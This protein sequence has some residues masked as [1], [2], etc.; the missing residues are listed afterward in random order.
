MGRRRP[1][2]IPGEWPKGEASQVYGNGTL[3]IGGGVVAGAQLARTGFPLVGLMLLALGLVIGGLL[4]VR[5]G[6]VRRRA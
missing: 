1:G 4:L 5:T 2:L 6:T 3:I